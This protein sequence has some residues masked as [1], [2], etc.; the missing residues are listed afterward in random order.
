MYSA[1]GDNISFLL[2]TIGLNYI[3]NWPQKVIKLISEDEWIIREQIDWL[4]KIEIFLSETETVK[5]RFSKRHLPKL[6]SHQSESN[7]WLW[8][9]MG[10]VKP[11]PG[12]K[13]A[14]PALVGGVSKV[15]RDSSASIHNITQLCNDLTISSPR[16]GRLKNRNLPRAT[17]PIL[18]YFSPTRA[19]QASN[20]A[21][22]QPVQ[23]ENAQCNVD[24]QSSQPAQ[25]PTRQLNCRRT[26]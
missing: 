7:V 2:H 25:A 16:V 8:V 9:V 15:R 21:S 20:Q 6:L 4:F 3:A 23:T 17:R 13:P 14:A 10:P 11:G 26:L 1:Y 19:R 18:S 12:D 22:N 24:A 5:Y